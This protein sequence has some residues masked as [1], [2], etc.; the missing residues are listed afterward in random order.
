[1]RYIPAR[2]WF[3]Q[4]LIVSAFAVLIFT[5]IRNIV[6]AMSDDVATMAT[7]GALVD[8]GTLAIPH[9][10]WL[11]D[12]VGIGAKGRD[13]QLYSKYGIGQ[14]ILSAPLYALGKLIPSSP[15]VILSHPIAASLSGAE[16]ASLLNPLAIGILLWIVQLLVEEKWGI[17]GGMAALAAAFTTPLFMAARMY[18]SEI[19]TGIFLA[20]AALA[21]LRRR[22]ALGILLVG[23]AALFRPSAIVFAA[24]WVILLIHR[25]RREWLRCGAAMAAG[26]LTL[27]M[28]NIIRY[29]S[30]FESGYGQQLGFSLQINGLLGFLVSPGRSIIL[31]VPWV[32][33]AVPAVYQ[34]AR[35]R[36]QY[37]LGLFIGT[38]VYI[39]VHAA[40][41]EWHGGWSY[42]PRLL[43]PIIPILSI[44]VAPWLT[45]RSALP[46]LLL[47]LVIELMTFRVNPFQVLQSA[48]QS[49]LTLDQTIWS[50]D[51]GALVLQARSLLVSHDG[52]SIVA[53]VMGCLALVGAQM[54]WRSRDFASNHKANLPYSD[55]AT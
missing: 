49:G 19:T 23:V 18:G 7:T 30:F 5:S 11:D 20:L 46:L 3:I 53:I 37:L 21:C 27:G 25:P 16:F 52:L 40:W 33:L 4:R 22:L 26:I 24:G 48:L 43:L 39:V 47:G 50:L 38:A 1:M 34:A 13:G 17:S 54:Y 8:H 31:F 32:L 28:F 36:D 2:Q 15:L 41:S 51:S 9:M 55:A 10:Q 12:Q 14:V 29:G 44:L 35:I 42:G 6:P 45:R